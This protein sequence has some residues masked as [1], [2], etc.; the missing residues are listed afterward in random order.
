MEALLYFVLWAA[1]IFVMMRFGCGA[2][3]MG[4][5]RGNGPTHDKPGKAGDTALHWVA[6]KKD[7]DPAC[8]RTVTTGDAKPSVYDGNVYYFCSR[9]CRE[10]FEAAPDLYV[11]GSDSHHP[12]TEHSHA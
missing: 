12:K 3:I 9:E 1:L 11:G 4:H 2:H 7:T 10:V 5:G 8:G 6:P